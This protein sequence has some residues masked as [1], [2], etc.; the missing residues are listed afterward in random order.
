MEQTQK[1]TAFDSKQQNRS[2]YGEVLQHEHKTL[3]HSLDTDRQRTQYCLNQ[4]SILIQQ[5]MSEM[6][7]FARQKNTGRNGIEN[8]LCFRREHE[9][10]EHRNQ[11]KSIQRKRIMD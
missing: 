5:G 9:Q 3:A 7:V 6:K 11:V 1:H 8:R 4:K 2:N 10:V